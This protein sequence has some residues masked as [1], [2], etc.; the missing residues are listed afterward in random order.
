M[1]PQQTL[2]QFITQELL[3]EPDGAELAPDD[4]LLLSGLID[5]LGVMRL[6]NIAHGDFIVMGAY[7]ALLVVSLTGIHPL[8]TLVLVVPGMAALG[9]LGQRLLLN[10]TLGDDILPPLLVTFG[11][12]IIIQN[13]LLELFSADSQKLQAGWI[14]TASIPLAGGLSVGVMPLLI[15]ASALAVIAVGKKCAPAGAPPGRA[16]GTLPP[17]I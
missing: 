2:T 9:Y 13:V 1:N 16:R 14:E 10:R 11:F 8:W 17:R 3:D 4:N 15:F 12:S 5:S 6:V 7:G